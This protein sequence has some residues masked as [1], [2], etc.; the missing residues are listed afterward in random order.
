MFDWLKSKDRKTAEKVLALLAKAI[1]EVHPNRSIDP[2]EAGIVTQRKLYQLNV[3]LGRDDGERLAAV[4]FD[5]LVAITSDYEH[6]GYAKELGTVVAHDAVLIALVAAAMHER[7][8]RAMRD[9]VR[10][11]AEQLLR[12]LNFHASPA[13]E[14]SGDGS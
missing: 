2:S 7:R 5:D 11:R 3:L 13:N 6:R 10:Q 1:K 14:P 12:Y 4:A 9:E 8:G